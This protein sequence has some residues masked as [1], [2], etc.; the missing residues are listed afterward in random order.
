[1]KILARENS[2]VGRFFRKAVYASTLVIA[3]SAAA[4]TA[5]ADNF[6]VNR[7][8]PP[9]G[10]WQSPRISN[11]PINSVQVTV[12][13]LD[14][15]AKDTF[16]TLQFDDGLTFDSGRHVQ[17]DHE[18]SHSVGWDGRSVVANGRRLVIAAGGGPVH[19]DNV[20]VTQQAEPHGKDRD[21]TRDHDDRDQ[22]DRDR[23][24][25]YRDQRDGYNDGRDDRRNDPYYRDERDYRDGRPRDGYNDNRDPYN[26]PPDDR[27]DPRYGR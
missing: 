21:R 11:G 8:L 3:L 1:M 26:Y 7:D 5:A 24:R 13:R 17:V 27:Y 23:D 16:L 20:V 10:T 2:S 14:P 22:H 18:F 15:K 25:D 12:R 6:Q 4:A 19:I 9:G